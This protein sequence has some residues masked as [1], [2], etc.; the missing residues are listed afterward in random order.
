MSRSLTVQD[1]VALPQLSGPETVTLCTQLE[2]Q[3]HGHKLPGGAD[4][5]LAD[6]VTSRV[7]LQAALRD[8]GPAPTSPEVIA[9]D[10]ALDHGWSSLAEWLSGWERLGDEASSPLANKIRV[11]IF[12]DGLAW[13]NTPYLAEWSESETR[14]G[15]LDAHHHEIESLGGKPFLARIRKLHAAYGKVLGVTE[16]KKP[17]PPHPDVRAAMSEAQAALR[18]YVGKVAASASRK[19]PKT[20]ELVEL[21]LA[22]VIGWHASKRDRSASPPEPG[23]AQT[24]APASPPDGSATQ[25]TS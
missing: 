16:S 10:R 13:L 20:A 9:A 25:T 4:E 18:E 7:A 8:K 17:A 22:P 14:L 6:V 15:K 23:A 1:L 3:A 5:A 24:T 19:R 12:P 21:L 2:T 11:A